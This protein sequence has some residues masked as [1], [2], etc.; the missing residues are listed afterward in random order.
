VFQKNV[1]L[2]KV[3]SRLAKDTSA[4]HALNVYK[5][6]LLLTY[7]ELEKL[8]Q[9][10]ILIYYSD[11]IEL[12]SISSVSKRYKT[13]I[14]VGS[15]L[16]ERIKNA[17]QEVFEMGYEHAVIIG[18]DCPEIKASIIENAFEGLI[19]NHEAVLGVARDG[20]YYLLGL[21]SVQPE[22]FVDMEWSTSFVAQET[23]LRLRKKG[24]EAVKLPILRDLDT[25]EDWEQT[26]ALLE[27]YLP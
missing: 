26:K 21:N 6:L 9:I 13:K 20:G 8:N 2:G 11:F 27:K 17:F 18:T 23:L 1:L 3:K 25:L 4:E 24:I 16:G 22:I 12:D 19:N 14:Q 7:H 5:A 15:D 10:D